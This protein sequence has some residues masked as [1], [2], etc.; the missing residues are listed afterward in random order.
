MHLT[1]PF[2][3]TRT[4]IHQPYLIVSTQFF[5]WSFIVSCFSINSKMQW[6]L[7]YVDSILWKKTPP[8]RIISWLLRAWFGKGFQESTVSFH[9]FWSIGV[10]IFSFCLCTLCYDLSFVCDMFWEH[11]GL[12]FVTN[13]TYMFL[14][15]IQ[16]RLRIQWRFIFA[17]AIGCYRL[18]L[19]V[20]YFT[21]FKITHVFF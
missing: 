7:I 21:Y 1:L 20:G 4:W 16:L 12:H 5:T 17:I 8:F 3:Q 14:R 18:Q 10:F 13:L 15:L 11:S 2:I 9:Q 6:Y 19:W